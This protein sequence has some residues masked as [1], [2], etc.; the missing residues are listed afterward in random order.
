MLIE[1]TYFGWGQPTHSI[2]C[3][4]QSWDVDIRRDEGVHPLAHRDE[5][6]HDCPNP[7][8]DH[9]NGFPRVTV[10]LVCRGCTVVHTVVGE[11]LGRP[12]S[13]LTQ[14]IGYGTRPR[15]LAGLYLWPGPLN[16][17]DHEVHEYLVSTR[18]VARLRPKD[19]VGQ[20]GR[21]PT[22]RGPQ[23]WWARA[24]RMQ[25]PV[26]GRLDWRRRISELTSLDAA[27]QWIAAQTQTAPVEV[28][29]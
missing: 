14:T 7:N 19:C 16:P 24:L 26:P 6:Q 25:P 23:L 15:Q 5:L 20:I 11:E 28:T 17:A 2:T 29:V 13:T 1:E 27:A 8:C 9:R 22:A 21:H 18:P 12:L 10:R 3:T 4:A